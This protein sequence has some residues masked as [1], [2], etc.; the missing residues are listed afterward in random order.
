M[1]ADPTRN[2]DDDTDGDEGNASLAAAAPSWA[3]GSLALINFTVHAYVSPEQDASASADVERM[4]AEHRAGHT[5]ASGHGGAHAHKVGSGQDVMAGRAAFF[6]SLINGNSRT[7]LASSTPAHEA[8]QT[9][10]GPAA[11]PALAP[12]TEAATRVPPKPIRRLISST[13]T[14]NAPTEKY[15]ELRI[16]LGFSVPCLETCVKSMAPNTRARFLVLPP[17]TAG[18]ARL[19]QVLRYEHLNRQRAAQGQ[20]PLRTTGCCGASAIAAL[21]STTSGSSDTLADAALQIQ[22]DLALLAG[23]TV[24]LELEIELAHVREPHT[25]TK[26]PWEMSAAAKLHEAPQR[27]AAGDAAYRRGD[28]AAACDEY[29]RAL[30]LLEALSLAPAVTDARRD[31]A[32]L[33][34]DAAREARR[35]IAERKRLE[36]RNDPIPPQYTQEAIDELLSAP[37]ATLQN[38]VA[39]TTTSSSDDPSI[40]PEL[41]MS[42]MN[43]CR[44][45]YAA[46]KL[47]LGDFPTVVVQCTEIIKN[48]KSSIK[49]LFR[50]AQA[51]RKIG[52]DLDLAQADLT[53]LRKLLVSKDISE[54]AP[55]FVELKREEKELGRKLN[56]AKLK[57]EK[58]FRN[59]FEKQAK[60]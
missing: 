46:C 38:D 30:V 18:Y 23:D 6:E 45:N 3:K 15:F 48:D 36:R 12:Q 11:S 39:T 60:E 27:K 22:R 53:T 54:D 9:V 25:Y 49:A 33:K 31:A 2:S 16:G 58:M 34:E 24:P 1:P 59:M 8:S 26:Q 41:V 29:A 43:T 5:H 13:H 52:R 19:E 10:A 44:L 28:C 56:E 40:D 42:L 14:T 55:E 35:R 17:D 21:L 7:Q 47:K 57:E 37:A 32:K 20:A 4:L 51:F 50:R